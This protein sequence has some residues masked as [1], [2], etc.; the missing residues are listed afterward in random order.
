MGQEEVVRKVDQCWGPNDRQHWSH[1]LGENSRCKGPAKGQGNTLKPLPVD[2][3]VEEL[4][5]QR[6][7]THVVVPILQIKGS[8]KYNTTWNVLQPIQR[9]I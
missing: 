2:V 7:Q 4:P 8:P 5:D 9:F 6:V 3:E 1:Q